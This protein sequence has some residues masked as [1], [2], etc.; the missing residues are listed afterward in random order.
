MGVRKDP[1]QDLQLFL[2]DQFF[3]ANFAHLVGVAGEGGM[4]DDAFAVG[5]DEERW[6]F[7][8]QGVVGELLQGGVE[9]A[10]R[11]FVFPTEIAAFPD[12]G[13]AVAAG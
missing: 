11:L 5:D 7:K 9:V 6:V 4:D 1:A 10:P 2:I 13:P 8:L 3:N 12:I